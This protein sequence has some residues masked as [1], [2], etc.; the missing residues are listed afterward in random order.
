MV[1][2]V[3]QIE[4]EHGAVDVLVNN[5]GYAL[6]APVEEAAMA[7]IRKQFETNVFGLVRLTQLVLPAMR[8]RRSGRIINLSSMGGRFT[9]P[10]GAFYHASKHAVEAISDALRLEVAPFGVRVSIIEPGPVLTDFATAAL[11]TMDTLDD[12]GEAASGPYDDF[13]RRLAESYHDAYS[14]GST[15]LASSS[16]SVAKTILKAATVRRPRP[17]Y[18]VGPIAHA[19]INSRRMLPDRA[20]DFLLRSQWPT[21]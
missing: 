7:D 3:K 16:E 5:A 9:F 4:V 1:S 18:V 13:K 6:Q 8:A 21:P 15:K 20:F 12:E 10:G 2:A 14:G 17:R 11:D 19:L